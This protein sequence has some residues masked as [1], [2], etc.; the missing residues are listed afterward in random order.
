MAMR[1]CTTLDV[2]TGDA[3]VNARH[4]KGAVGQ[5]LTQRPVGH[6][7]LNKVPAALE[8]TLQTRMDVEVGR[9]TTHQFTY[10]DLTMNHRYEEELYMALS[11]SNTNRNTDTISI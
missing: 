6:A 9:A 2:L 7:V 1:E 11:T 10:N 4:E 8:H 5:E 3:H